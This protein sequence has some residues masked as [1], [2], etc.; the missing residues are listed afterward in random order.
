[1]LN[2]SQTCYSGRSNEC[3]DPTYSCFNS[4]DGCVINKSSQITVGILT[5]I[6][7]GTSF[8]LL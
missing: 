2:C 5:I 1:M 8:F 4:P 6:L 3:L 7:I